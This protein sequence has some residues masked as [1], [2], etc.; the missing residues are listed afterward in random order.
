MI[1]GRLI[2]CLRTLRWSAADLAQELGV[3]VADAVKWLDGRQPPP[4]AVAAWLEALAK[5]RR[6]LPPPKLVPTRELP[7]IGNTPSDEIN[8][9]TR[10]QAHVRPAVSA[11]S[12]MCQPSRS[13]KERSM[14]C[15]R[16][17]EPVTI[18]VGL[19]FPARIE[20]AM[21]AYALLADWPPASRNG[22]H[23]V[24]LNACRAAINGEIDAETARATF[25]AFARRNDILASDP[26]PAISGVQA[27]IAQRL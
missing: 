1:A 22:A 4:L 17:E 27:R 7:L 12:E 9:P 18:L 16:F 3:S 23:T 2:E 14:N 6:L 8:I 15:T 24:A 5:A 19:G 25:V 20:S 21:E 26:M 10:W 13:G 11:P